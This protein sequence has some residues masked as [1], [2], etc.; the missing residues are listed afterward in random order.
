MTA[1]DCELAKTRRDI[2]VLESICVR[3]DRDLEKR[4]RLAYRQFHQ[5]S[6]T[7]D[8]TDFKTVERTIDGILR[9][10]GPKEDTCLLK[11]NLDGRFHRLAEVKEDLMLCPALATRPAG[12][13][14]LADLDFQEG[15]Y[16]QAY[17][18]LEALIEHD[19]TWDVLARLAH[20]EGKIGHFEEAECLY[21]EAKD[22]LTAKELLSFAWLELQQGSLA[23]SRGRH[24]EARAHY[25]R[26]SASFP[27]HWHTDEHIAR[28][29]AAEGEL[30]EAV[31]LLRS[32]I[33]RA[34][35]PELKQLLGEL[36]TILGKTGEAWSWLEA[37]VA[38][39]L[40]SAGE[41]EVHYY[42]HL[43][44]W[45]G[46]LGGRPAE[47]VQWA[48]KDVALRS[49]YSTQSALAWA[50][51]LNSE[52]AEGLVWIRQALC[53]GVQDTGI[54]AIASSLSRAAGDN[55]QGDH[56]AREA[57]KISPTGHSVHG[58]H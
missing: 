31:T 13:V 57:L 10:F 1:Y 5:A 34:P 15:R 19:R 24:R 29:L 37:A 56:Y 20:W 45:Y 35:K 2:R 49:N 52:I 14:V 3:D 42:H 21:D 51:L 23:L 36:L 18:S 16:D 7:E 38:A 27:G 8:D 4:T 26:A 33:A 22:E 17:A 43:V 30:E 47:A 48:R 54:F 11:A 44:H 39:F 28:L 12:R 25:R 9:D 40:T 58:R 50:L 55:V 32:V 41:G 53:S 6:L 46:D